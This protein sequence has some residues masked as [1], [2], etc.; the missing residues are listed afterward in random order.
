[1]NY[2][3]LL[4]NGKAYFENRS[5][6]NKTTQE[7]VLDNCQSLTVHTCH[8]V[9]SEINLAEYFTS[10]SIYWLFNRSCFEVGKGDVVH[11]HTHSG[12]NLYEDVDLIEVLWRKGGSY[13]R[14]PEDNPW[15]GGIRDF[16]IDIWSGVVTGGKDV[17]CIDTYDTIMDVSGLRK[18]CLWGL[19]SMILGLESEWVAMRGDEQ[20]CT[21]MWATMCSLSVLVWSD[22]EIDYGVAKWGY[23]GSRQSYEVTMALGHIQCTIE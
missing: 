12:L 10:D 6:H 2:S 11:G 21:N 15:D 18:L 5:R 1:M 7:I 20:G 17:R 8:G 4:Y 19:V 13:G 23:Y 22:D 16:L 14:T 3:G 9:C